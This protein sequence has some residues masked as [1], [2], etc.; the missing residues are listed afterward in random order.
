MLGMVARPPNVA[1]KV[2]KVFPEFFEFDG[3]KEEIEQVVATVE[4]RENLTRTRLNATS[5]LVSTAC[6]MALEAQEVAVL[7]GNGSW[8]P[9]SEGKLI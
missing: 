2:I 8:P 4:N 3:T 1:N 5:L 7:I 9:G 6:L